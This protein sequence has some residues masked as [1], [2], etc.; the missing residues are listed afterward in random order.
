MNPST[1]FIDSGAL[2]AVANRGD[3]YE[4]MARQLWEKI[5]ESGYELI[6]TEHIL[7][8]V[9]TAICRTQ[10]PR[11]AAEWV[12]MQLDMGLI[13]WCQPLP[14]DLISATGWL[15]KL[16]DQRVNFTD[17]LSFSVMNRMGLRCAFSFDQ[18]FVFAGFQIFSLIQSP[19]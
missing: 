11:R 3:Q 10:S 18:H 4:Q 1:L 8:E 13:R 19:E 7:D 12:R 14:D 5:A 2:V 16:T 17:C 15:G 6:S 9:A